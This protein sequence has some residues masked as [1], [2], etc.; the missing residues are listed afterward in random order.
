MDVSPVVGT[1]T[2]CLLLSGVLAVV[3]KRLL[4]DQPQPPRQLEDRHV[5]RR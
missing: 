5:C 1:T 3:V 2:K 4:E